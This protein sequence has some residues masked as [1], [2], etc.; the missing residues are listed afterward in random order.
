MHEDGTDATDAAG[1]DE[2][3]G[4][5]LRAVR[6]CCPAWLAGIAEDICQEALIKVVKVLE[7]E[8]ERPEALSP[9]YVR[10]AAYH[11][12]I[13]AIRA[14]RQRRT[15]EVELEGADVVDR[16]GPV[17]AERR[18]A[19]REVGHGIRECLA[20]LTRP[21]RLAVILH[22]HGHTLAESSRIM[23]WRETRTTNLVYRGLKDLRACL[24]GKGL[25]P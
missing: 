4:R 21:R 24:A 1:V 15:R 17:T 11:A 2:L 19:S 22:L 8:G 20:T 5:L 3:R 9:S 10:K 16:A 25:A 23:G 13:D 18:V 12:T 14:Q 7:R 6:Q